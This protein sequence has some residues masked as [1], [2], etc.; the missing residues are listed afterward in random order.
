MER[1]LFI[2]FEGIDGTGKSTQACLLAE[3][4]K[5]HGFSVVLTREPGGTPLAE[6][7]RALLLYEKE[8]N[9]APV[10]EVMLYA[11]ARAQH[12]AEVIWPA[13]HRGEIVICERFSDSTLA[14]QGYATGI[15][16]NLIQKADSIATGGLVPDL[17]F[18]L[19][20]ETT[21]GWARVRERNNGKQDRMEA[22]GSSF[23]EKVRNGYLAIAAQEEN[24]VKNI[25]C[26][27]KKVSEVQQI[28]WEIL[29]KRIN[30]REGK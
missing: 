9:L 3:K 29:L 14:Y 21:E 16:R 19:D 7:I 10:T 23:L 5:K 11:A 12:V 2:T 6:K 22:K 4:L 15:D 20:L 17:T 28:I 8:I 24:R 27:G 1:G 13:L 18:L 25:N 30:C 26:S